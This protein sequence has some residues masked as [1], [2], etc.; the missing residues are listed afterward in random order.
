MW[1]LFFKEH[2]E[3][4]FQ[5]MKVLNMEIEESIDQLVE[6]TKELIRKTI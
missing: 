1:G 4:L 2:Y 3:R 6:I 5:N